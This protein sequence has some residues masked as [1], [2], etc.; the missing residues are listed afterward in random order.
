MKLR[1]DQGKILGLVTPLDLAVIIIIVLVG[2][3]M[4]GIYRPAAP[5][6]KERQVTLGILIRDAP[7]Y[8]L[9]SLVVGQDLFDDNTDA[10]L[11]KI[12]SI[13]D[14]PA[15][16]LL[17]YHGELR[18]TRSPRNRDIRLELIKRRG[19]IETG[20]A[21]SGVYLGKIPARVGSRVRAHTRYTAVS[22]EIIYVRFKKP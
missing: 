4:I 18:L 22:G 8:L 19:R 9:K 20:Q 1:D 6:Q 14:E 17:P 2:A 15:E 12:H 3:K 7:P 16:V 11:G 21:R 13:Q 5:R 10:Y